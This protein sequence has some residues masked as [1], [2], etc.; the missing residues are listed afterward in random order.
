MKNIYTD[1]ATETRDLLLEDSEKEEIEGVKFK[2]FNDDEYNIKIHFIEIINEK[3]EESMGKAIGN[4]I[5]LESDDLKTS[6][7]DAH[8][9][10]IKVLA[11]EL[12]KLHNLS[13]TGSALIIG[14]GNWNVT[15]D[16]LGPKVISKILVTRHIKDTLPDGIKNSLR[17]VS[18]LAPGVLGITGVETKETVKGLV[19]RVKPDLVIAVDA[20]A[21]RNVSR[22][23]A[24]IQLSDTGIA[25]GSGLGNNQKHL[26]MDTLGVKVI[27]IGVPTVVSAATLIND[28]LDKILEEMIKECEEGSSFY[29]M[30]N[31]LSSQEKHSLITNILN[32][33]DGNMFV[34]PKDVDSVIDRLSNIIANA[35]NISLHPG[36]TKDD[37]NR[38]MY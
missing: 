20:L 17:Y 28:S 38:Y 31:S 21:A 6:D 35:I 24:T 22:I 8:E 10:I 25:P 1:L 32:P 11:D 34:T 5:T 12:S 29:E 9:R 30:L 16:A 33:Y 14:L 7:I 3:G 18:A 4:Y 23:N 19:E 37:I 15:P 36:I 13:E 27:A 26:S 2:T